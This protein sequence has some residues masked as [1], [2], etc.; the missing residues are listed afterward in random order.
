MKFRKEGDRI[1]TF[2]QNEDK[3]SYLS[4]DGFSV[5][6]VEPALCVYRVNELLKAKSHVRV[7]R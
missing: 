7:I 1:H 3:M 6:N 5:A 4:G 2:R